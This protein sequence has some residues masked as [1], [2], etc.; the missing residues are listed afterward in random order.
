FFGAVGLDPLRDISSVTL[1]APGSDVQNRAL[2]IVSGNFNVER[3][4]AAADE[5]I[6][7]DPE[8][9]RI[10]RQEN[11]RI[12]ENK[13]KDGN[14]PG[15]AAFADRNTLL[16]ARSMRPILAAAQ[17]AGRPAPGVKKELQELIR[18]ADSK[19]SLWSTA[20][21]TSE[22]REVLRGNAQTAA[23]ADK[24]SSFTGA[25]VLGDAV[26]AAI[27]IHATDARAAVEVHK[28]M[29]ALKGFVQFAALS[30]KEYGPL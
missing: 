8:S 11:L 21:A 20:L 13:G 25:V 5:A 22:V 1:A 18:E 29:E 23:V 30:N 15:Y 4:H 12:Y 26:Q 17:S 6:R 3:I 9:L 24:I 16:I 2:F 19:E 14:S 7:S 27:Q 10:H 28:L